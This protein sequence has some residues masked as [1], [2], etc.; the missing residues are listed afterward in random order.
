MTFMTDDCIFQ[1]AGG[2]QACGARFEGRQAVRT[3]FEQAWTDFP[4]AQWRNGRALRLRRSRRVRM[5]LHRHHGRRHPH[6]D[7][8]HATSSPFVMADRGEER[9][10]QGPSTAQDRLTL[11]TPGART[12]DRPRSRSMDMKPAT[13][14]PGGLRPAIRSAGRP[15]PRARPR[16]RAHLLGRPAPGTP[17]EDDG[18]VL[19]D[20]D[21]DVVIIG[22]GFTG[23]AT[24]LFLAREHGIRATVLEANRS[25]WGCTSR[26][27]GQG[28]NASG[29]LYRSQWIERWGKEMATR[30][31]CRDPRR[32]RDL[33]EPGRR[34][35]LRRAAGRP[36][37]RRAPREEDGLPAQRGA[38][39]ARGVRLRHAHARRR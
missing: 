31:R 8:R 24:A 38:G 33:Q 11:W 27:G 4:D 13:S 10:P 34:V 22:S 17:P 23:L 15:Q 19:R 12:P 37:L 21:A 3:A 6:R 28:Q 36:S 26:N 25:I 16:L 29:R 14:A 18:P 1:A 20:I 35:P 32:L 9:L 30:A 7:R 39:H 2:P 5:D